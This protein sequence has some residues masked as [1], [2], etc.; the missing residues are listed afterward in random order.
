[1]KVV[2]RG[3]P[4]D[5]R[6]DDFP[7]A[8]ERD[9]IVMPNPRSTGPF[10]EVTYP[11]FS[12]DHVVYHRGGKPGEDQAIE[13]YADPD[14]AWIS[15]LIPGWRNW[16]RVQ[17]PDLRPPDMKHIPLRGEPVGQRAEDFGGIPMEYRCVAVRVPDGRIFKV[18]YTSPDPGDFGVDETGQLT[19]ERHLVDHAIHQA[20]WR[21]LPPCE[22]PE[23]SEKGSGQVTVTKTLGTGRLAGKRRAVGDVAAFCPRHLY[24]LHR[25]KPGGDEGLPD[26]LAADAWYPYWLTGTAGILPEV[27]TP[28]GE[29]GLTMRLC[30]LGGGVW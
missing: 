7:W 28:A 6:E 17:V 16:H 25:V 27:K 29:G 19:W 3:G 8:P 4:Y 22:V 1:M 10:Y 15:H 30:G 5:G 11:R 18:T 23:C 24:D 12:T 2:L 20:E 13:Y 26:W 9:L 14:L 21:S